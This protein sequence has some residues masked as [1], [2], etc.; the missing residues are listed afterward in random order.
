MRIHHQKDFWSGVMFLCVGLAF[1]IGA[2]EYRLGASARP[3]PGF[4]PLGLGALLACFG[5]VIALNA[6]RPLREADGE[7]RRIGRIA[8]RPLLVIVASIAIFGATLPQLGLAISLPLLVT[9]ISLAG[10][11]FHWRGVL[12]SALVLTLGSWA[13]F[14]YGLGLVIPVWPV[15]F[16][17]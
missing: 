4:F 10:D 6:L 1:A 8:W 15:F 17:G 11:E 5:L 9:V 12:I 7:S 16:G 3:G 14:V 2:T 13:V